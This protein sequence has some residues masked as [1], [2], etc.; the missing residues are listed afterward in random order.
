M[1]LEY[2]GNVEEIEVVCGVR[3]LT[4]EFVNCEYIY[5][6]IYEKTGLDMYLPIQYFNSYTYQILMMMLNKEDKEGLYV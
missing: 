6:Y 3:L 4:L 5:I 2:Y 1:V